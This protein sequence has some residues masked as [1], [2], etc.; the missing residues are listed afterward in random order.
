MAE[1]FKYL[2]EIEGDEL[3]FIGGLLKDMDNT[4]A[5]KFSMVYR[6]RRK[7][8]QTIL[9]MALVGFIGFA[10]IHRFYLNQIGMGVLY[11]FTA[12]ICFIGT[13]IDLVN[14]R[15]LTLQYNQLQAQQIL[16]MIKNT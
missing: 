1:V 15:D 4:A 12:G 13:I 16:T 2:P 6:A 7:D 8:P 10:G 14:Y 9:L 3:M 11:F 5:E